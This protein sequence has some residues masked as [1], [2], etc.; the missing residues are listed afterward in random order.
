MKTT[1]LLM[2]A[3][4]VLALN[5]PAAVFGYEAS[6]DA[7]T[8]RMMEMIVDL[9]GHDAV[10]KNSG[11]LMRCADGGTRKVAIVKRGIT[12]TYRGDYRTCREGGSV[13]DGIYEIV[14]KGDEIV[15][16]TEERSIDGQ[17]FD[18]AKEGNAA[19]VRTLL[20]ARADVNHAESIPLADGGSLDELSPL[21]AATM[22]GSLDTVKV[23]VAGGAWV[24]YLNSMAVNSLWIAAHNG[25]LEIVKHLAAHGAYL[26][27]SNSED[28]TPLMAAAMNGHFGVVKFLVEKKVRIDAVHK[29]G[30]TAL[31]FAVARGH[32]DIARFLIDAGADVNSRNAF[33]VTA[34]IIAAAE[35]NDEV[36]RKLLEKR[37]DTTPRTTDGKTALDVARAREMHSVVDLLEELE[38]ERTSEAI[39]A[40]RP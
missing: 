33:G 32:T 14:F 1:I 38:E 36:A 8:K 20:K 18:A 11:K 17:L 16:S 12:T 10:R 26:N 2:S 15:S 28:V 7:T 19:K 27:N 37:A 30:D 5:N 34:L 3:G 21:M 40:D 23:L 35:G 39:P 9:G 31:M 6:Q 22:A 24:N 29:E 13:R 4:V 25:N